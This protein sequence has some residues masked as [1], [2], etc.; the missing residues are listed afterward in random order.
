[1]YTISTL[2]EDDCIVTSQNVALK[3][4]RS[5]L[6]TFSFIIW[7]IPRA[8]TFFRSACHGLNN[9][10]YTLFEDAFKYSNQEAI[11]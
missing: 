5:L 9:Q 2:S 7:N 4:L 11:N 8:G 6:N 10:E 3:F 1:M